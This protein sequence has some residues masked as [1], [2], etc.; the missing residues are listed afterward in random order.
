[1]TLVLDGAR[2]VRVKTVDRSGK[3]VA[4]VK[5]GLLSIEKPGHRFGI[6]LSGTV[7]T[8]LMTGEDGTA[9]FDWMPSFGRAFPFIIRS[10]DYFTAD[11][12]TSLMADK[13]ADEQTITLLP[14]EGLSGRVTHADGRPGAGIL[15]KAEGKGAG[16]NG[17]HGFARTDADGRYRMRVHSE[18][19]YVVAVVDEQWGAPYRAGLVVRAGRPVE[20]V[21]FV[22]GRATWLHGRVTTAGRSGRAG[23]R[24]WISVRI[25]GGMIPEEIR[26]EGR[27][28]ARFAGSASLTLGTPVGEDGRYELHL[29]P[30]NYT[31]QVPLSMMKMTVERLTIPADPQ[32]AEI[33][34]DFPTPKIAPVPPRPGPPPH[35]PRQIELD[36]RP[37]RPAD[38]T[39][40]AAPDTS[41]RLLLLRGDDLVP[42]GDVLP[43]RP[44][45][46]PSATQGDAGYRV[47]PAGLKPGARPYSDREYAIRDLPEGLSGLSLLQTRMGHKGVVDGRFSV[48]VSAARPCYVFVAIDERALRTYKRHGTPSWLEEFAPTGHRIKT[49]E[50]VM[51][52]GDGAYRVF[53]RKAPA[54][55]IALG[56]PGMDETANAMYFAFFAE[57]GGDREP[58]DG[59]EHVPAPRTKD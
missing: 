16:N 44:G 5:V 6:N 12:V 36:L 52:R 59:P 35:L 42:S 24:E 34:R 33:V 28:E 3:P 46:S 4:G 50:P 41:R 45:V 23:P 37:L 51:S 56:P 27:K 58:R 54:G 22:L 57:P 38:V 7:G 21:D 39:L 47:V 26:A 40:L 43:D 11:G 20:G 10:A 8:W 17:F 48:V 29:G 14:L 55:R 31:V 30:G 9:V 53:V 18:Q 25:D 13:P 2:T 1:M 19:A 49:D 32:P 15:V